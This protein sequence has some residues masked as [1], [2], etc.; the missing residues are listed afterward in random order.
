MAISLYLSGGLG[1]QMFNY[2][3]ARTLADRARTDLVLDLSSYMP[4]WS[5]ERP[6]VLD[7]F[8]IRARLRHR[9]GFMSPQSLPKRLIRR[10]KEDLFATSF[11]NKIVYSDQ[12]SALGSRTI[13]RGDYVSWKFF[14]E[15][16]QKIQQDFSV[17]DETVSELLPGELRTRLGEEMSVGM[18]VRRGD[19]L[20]PPYSGILLPDQKGYYLRAMEEL[21]TRLGDPVFYVV[22][23]DVPW[24]RSSF[25]ELPFTIRFLDCAFGYNERLLFDFHLLRSCNHHIIANSAF[26]WWSAWL[27]KRPGQIVISPDRWD[28]QQRLPIDEIAPRDWIKLPAGQT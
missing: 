25:G 16:E 8:R 27:A 28:A 26:S 4:P 9:H 7:H 6:F 10:L 14:A 18:H 23:D 3:A 17:P 19:L 5:I 22:S 12:F 15:N 11:E 13:L 24:C 2:A 21:Q 20:T 1:N